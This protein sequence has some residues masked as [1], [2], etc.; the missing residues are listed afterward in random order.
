MVSTSGGLLSF[1]G[2]GEELQFEFL[3]DAVSLLW[4]SGEILF[5]LLFIC[6]VD[7]FEIEFGGFGEI[8]GFVFGL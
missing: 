6:D 2:L 3:I 8:F 5:D 4:F 1:A 7:H